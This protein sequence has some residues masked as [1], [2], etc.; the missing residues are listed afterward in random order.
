MGDIYRRSGPSI[1]MTF[2]IAGIAALCSSMVALVRRW[3]VLRD[4]DS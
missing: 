1:H 3:I 4:D 2:G